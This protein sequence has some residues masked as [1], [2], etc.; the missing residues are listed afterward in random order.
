MQ[1]NAD[2]GGFT[3]KVSRG[4]LRVPQRFSGPV[5][6][7]CLNDRSAVVGQVGLTGEQQL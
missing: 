3:Y 5:P 4:S 2:G 1:K 6:V 7:I